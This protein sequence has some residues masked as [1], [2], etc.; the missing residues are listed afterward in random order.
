[1]PRISMY[2]FT[3][4]SICHLF[5]IHSNH[6]SE[7]TQFGSIFLT[8]FRDKDFDLRSKGM[9]SCDAFFLR[10]LHHLLPYSIPPLLRPY[11]FIFVLS[12]QPIQTSPRMSQEFHRRRNIHSLTFTPRFA[13]RYHGLHIVQL[14]VRPVC[15]IYSD[16][17]FAQVKQ[18]IGELIQ[19]ALPSECRPPAVCSNALRASRSASIVL[20]MS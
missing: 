11:S 16:I 9:V 10:N 4:T 3:I 12:P 20:A 17:N 5:L 19:C 18:R 1:M 14:E 2:M 8:L 6:R 7:P 15:S 13:C